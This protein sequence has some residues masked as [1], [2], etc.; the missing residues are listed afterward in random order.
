MRAS[1]PPLVLAALGLG[2]CAQILGLE[3]ADSA[4]ANEPGPDAAPGGVGGD[5]EEELR[6]D[7]LDS[8]D[9]QSGEKC[10][11]LIDDGNPESGRTTCVPRGFL[12]LGQSCSFEAGHDECDDG[13]VCA[14][15]GA[16]AQ[17]CT[18]FDEGCTCREIC[19]PFS[20]GCFAS[21]GSGFCEEIFY[22]FTDA[23]KPVGLCFYEQDA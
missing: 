9:C 15:A 18:F 21:E 10:G 20:E 11:W 17:P 1:I 3:R 19:D 14:G 6:C 2:G 4:Q 23:A 5:E 16:D 13:L 12:A 8:V 7:P 22:P